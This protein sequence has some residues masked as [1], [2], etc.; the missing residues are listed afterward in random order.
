MVFHGTI[1]TMSFIPVVATILDRGSTLT[2]PSVAAAMLPAQ[3]VCDDPKWCLPYSILVTTTNFCPPR[4]WCDPSNHHFDL[5]QPI[6]QHIAQ[7]KSGIVPVIYR[8]YP[9]LVLLGFMNVLV[10][11]QKENGEL[12]SLF[13]MFLRVRSR[14]RGGI[15]FT[16][17]G[18]SYFN[19]V[20]VINVGGAGYVHS[21][22]IKGSRTRWQPISR[23]WGQNWQSNAYLNGQTL[24]FLVTTSDGHSVLSY[25]V[26][27]PG[28]S[29][30]QTYSG[31]QFRFED[32]I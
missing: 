25:N 12:T 29:F 16:I 30:G 18:H 7:Y 21:V 15:R 32:R 1:P 11:I 27:P 28:W 4:G 19:L 14:R 3:W 17:N 26:A 6:S 22:A 5:S 9:Y 31:L 10:N 24:S 20:L 8:R 13:L 23:N 2:P